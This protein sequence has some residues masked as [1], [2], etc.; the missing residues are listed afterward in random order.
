M[1]V[2]AA[3]CVLP[4]P[5]GGAVGTSLLIAQDV[6]TREQ[7]ILPSSLEVAGGYRF[8]AFAGNASRNTHGDEPRVHTPPLGREGH[9]SGSHLPETSRTREVALLDISIVGNNGGRGPALA[10]KHHIQAP[11]RAWLVPSKEPRPADYPQGEGFFLVVVPRLHRCAQAEV[12][13]L[14]L[15]WGPAPEVQDELRGLAHSVSDLD[16]TGPIVE[17]SRAWRGALGYAGCVLQ[18][19][20]GSGKGCPVIKVGHASPGASSALRCR[21]ESS[22]PS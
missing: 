2:V 1:L 3:A 22:E 9:L 10:H 16:A 7:Y 8:Y 19:V 11:C 14:P 18:R 13:A 15:P 20:E 17:L 4:F 6:Y 5:V 21:R 12:P